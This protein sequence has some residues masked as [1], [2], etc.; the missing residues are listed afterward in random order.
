MSTMGESGEKGKGV[1]RD[2]H[3][4]RWS[5]MCTQSFRSYQ[6]ALWIIIICVSP[7]FLLVH[8]R[9]SRSMEHRPLWTT[10]CLPHRLLVLGPACILSLS[11]SCLCYYSVFF[12]AHWHFIHKTVYRQCILLHSH[13]I[14]QRALY[15]PNV[16]NRTGCKPTIFLFFPDVC[17][18]QYNT[19]SK[20]LLYILSNFFQCYLVG[21][22]PHA[23]LLS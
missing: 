3:I 12:A 2:C 19:A 22:G 13:A 18:L 1:S 23:H 6:F 17:P 21:G 11:A 20:A 5:L 14:T 9:R 7:K 4:R 15:R 10:A 16:W 8:S